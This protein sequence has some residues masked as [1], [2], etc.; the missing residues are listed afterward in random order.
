MSK[1]LQNCEEKRR[2]S[3][4]YPLDIHSPF[5]S[6]KLERRWLKTNIFLIS[7]TRSWMISQT[8]RNQS[9]K[10]ASKSTTRRINI[11]LR[12]FKST[13]EMHY[14]V[15]Y[16]FWQRPR[17]FLLQAI[18]QRKKFDGQKSACNKILP[19][20]LQ[21]RQR[22]RENERFPTRFGCKISQV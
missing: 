5:L 9:T 4:F 10:F 3:V 12:K 8:T 6:I 15:R 19:C 20:A 14:D 17:K 18:D 11:F 22:T 16:N 2:N 7:F 21:Q 13:H 1:D